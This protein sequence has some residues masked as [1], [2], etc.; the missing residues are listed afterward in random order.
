MMDDRWNIGR[1]IIAFS[2][3]FMRLLAKCY[4]L[5]DSYLFSL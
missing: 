1:V 2:V 3:G 5:N 4:E